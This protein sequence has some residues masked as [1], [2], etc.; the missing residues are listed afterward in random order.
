MRKLDTI[1]KEHLLDHVYATDNPDHSGAN[2][3][4]TDLLE[5]VRDRL[6]GFQA[7]PFPCE[8][9]EKALACIEEALVYLKQR[10]DKRF[11]RGVLSKEKI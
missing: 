2:H 4:Y 11:Q 3:F 9:N 1:Q 5:V 10:T 6:K 8:E 7:G